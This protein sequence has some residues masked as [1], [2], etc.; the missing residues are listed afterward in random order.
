MQ[1]LKPTNLEFFCETKFKMQ[2]RRLSNDYASLILK[3]R[4]PDFTIK[5][6]DASDAARRVYR[7]SAKLGST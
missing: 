7:F 2:D 4:N 5:H 6:F 1:N 3:Y